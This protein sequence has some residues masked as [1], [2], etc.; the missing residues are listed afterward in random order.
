MQGSQDGVKLLGHGKRKREALDN[1]NRWDAVREA[2]WIDKE[3]RERQFKRIKPSTQDKEKQTEQR[4]ERN[5][6]EKEGNETTE[7][8][9]EIDNS[10][11]VGILQ[12]PT[13]VQLH[14][15]DFLPVSTLANLCLVC[16]EWNDLTD[17]T[18]FWRQTFAR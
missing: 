1:G 10:I 12:L 3:D 15:F 8:I 4:I 5:E 13:E 18:R 2:M 6:G 14:I 17:D 9:V 11:T 16:K 7:Q